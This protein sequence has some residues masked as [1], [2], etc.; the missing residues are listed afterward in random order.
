MFIVETRFFDWET[1]LVTTT[2]QTNSVFTSLWGL[3]LVRTLL[4]LSAEVERLA[5]MRL[6]VC[7][8]TSRRHG[9][10]KL[11]SGS[12]NRSTQTLHTTTETNNV[13]QQW[14][15]DRRRH[16]SQSQYAKSRRYWILCKCL[17]PSDV[18]P[19]LEPFV[20]SAN[21]YTKSKMNT[22]CVEMF[23]LQRFMS[24]EMESVAIVSAFKRAQPKTSLNDS[25]LLVSS[26]Q[27]INFPPRLIYSRCLELFG[28]WI[29]LDSQI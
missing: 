5:R 22:Q 20:W 1:K 27:Q 26:T 4:S 2:N 7:A 24:S 13:R 15:K 21:H 9:I 28:F 14:P 6:S 16:Q 3:R 8:L 19:T 23:R 10:C 11:A 29:D 17:K 12:C 18:G 25:G